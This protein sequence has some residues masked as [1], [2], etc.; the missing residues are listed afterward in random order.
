MFRLLATLTVASLILSACG[1]GDSSI[2]SE[3]IP[4]ETV[5]N[6]ASQRMVDIETMR[7]DMRIKGETYIDPDRTIRLLHAIGDMARPN[8]VS[9]E[10][11]VEVLGAQTLSMRMISVG[12]DS[13]TTDIVTGNWGDAPPEFGYD[14][15][16][17]YDN[18]E[19]LGPVIGKILMPELVG[20]EEVNG[21]QAYHVSGTSSG[22]TIAPMTNNT[23]HGDEIGIDVWID[24][25]MWDILRV[26]VEEPEGSEAPNPATW[27]MNLTEH[28]KQMSIEPPI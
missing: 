19:G 15:S 22:E 9:V 14:P 8:M 5:L 12:G 13:W 6:N 28:N 11:Q 21:R 24:G 25:E 10:F 26:V 27:T 3:D 20:V 4:V 1:G 18:Q 17:L 23:M 7:F 2:L 16:M